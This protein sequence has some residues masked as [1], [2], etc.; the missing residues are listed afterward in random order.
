MRNSSESFSAIDDDEGSAS[1]GSS[2]PDIDPDD[3]MRDF[4][5]QQHKEKKVKSK[6]KSKKHEELFPEVAVSVIQK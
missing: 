5:I 6:K 4:L 1:D 2:L 3:P